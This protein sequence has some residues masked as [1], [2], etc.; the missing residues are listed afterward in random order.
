M[1][2]CIMWKFVS[3]TQFHTV[4]YVVTTVKAFDII[5]IIIIIIIIT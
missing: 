4:L 2:Y 1:R 3:S 5:I